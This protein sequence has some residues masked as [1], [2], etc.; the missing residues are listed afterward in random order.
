MS[1][2]RIIPHKSWTWQREAVGASTHYFAR[3][4]DFPRS[5]LFILATC[6]HAASNSRLRSKMRNCRSTWRKAVAIFSSN[7]TGNTSNG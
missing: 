2:L 3:T 5:S 4:D 7:N 6:F 1:A